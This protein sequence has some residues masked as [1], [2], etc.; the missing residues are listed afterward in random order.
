MTD[1]H[2]VG[3]DWTFETNKFSRILLEARNKTS[4]ALRIHLVSTVKYCKV[5]LMR[6]KKAVMLIKT[7]CDLFIRLAVSIKIQKSED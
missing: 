2:G 7:L 4:N 1:H 5:F 6:L 3:W